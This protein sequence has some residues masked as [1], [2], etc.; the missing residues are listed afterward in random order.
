MEETPQPLAERPSQDERIMAALSNVMV[1]IFMIGL[2]V[3]IVIWITQKDKSRYVAF[4]ALQAT[5]Y[6][7]ALVLLYFL[8]FG[9]YFA[10]FFGVFSGT[11]VLSA[12][13]SNF[14]PEALLF[15]PFLVLGSMMCLG[16]LGILYGLYAAIMTF[17]GK[18][19]HYIV[20]GK[21]LE[22]NLEKG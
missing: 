16:I 21:L 13:N 14:T 15:V 22:R 12:A 20:I 1:L 8:S 9:C 17:Q 11:A 6:Q 5:V 7:I 19:F 3:P 4:Q 2:V 18:D 10:S